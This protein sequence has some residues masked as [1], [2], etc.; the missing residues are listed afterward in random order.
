METNMCSLDLYYT[1]FIF[2]DIPH[3]GDSFF[4]SLFQIQISQILNSWHSNHFLIKID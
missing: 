3:F 1:T 2:G 4:H